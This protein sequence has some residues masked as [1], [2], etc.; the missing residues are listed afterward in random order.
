MIYDRLSPLDGAK[1]IFMTSAFDVVIKMSNR[2]GGLAI[3][4]RMACSGGATGRVINIK[5]RT[6]RAKQQ[7]AQKAKLIAALNGIEA[8]GPT[9]TGP[10]I[11]IHTYMQYTRP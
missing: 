6:D 2:L 9:V 3:E 10:Y 5:P 8:A 11:Y 1:V 7:Q 4:L